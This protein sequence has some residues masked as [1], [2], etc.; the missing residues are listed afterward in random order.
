MLDM[1]QIENL[2][3]EGG[4]IKCYAY[5]P[6]LKNLL[7]YFPKFLKQIK[8]YAGTSAGSIIATF[9]CLDTDLDE[10]TEIIK[11]F[12]KVEIISNSYFKFFWNIYYL[13]YRFGMN[14]N[15]VLEELL[16]KAIRDRWCEITSIKDYDP[17]F[18][19]I[20]DLLNKDLIITSS[21]IN[22]QGLVYFSSISTP[23]VPIYKAILSSCC[24]PG[25]FNPV[26]YDFNPDKSCK[27]YLVDGGL[28]LNYPIFVFDSLD[29][30]HSFK[31]ES[32][33]KKTLGFAIITNSDML[34]ERKIENFTNFS[35]NI[36]SILST[37][38]A[39]IYMKENDWDRTI[40]IFT[41]HYEISDL[42]LDNKRKDLDRNGMES[43]NYFIKNN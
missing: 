15:Q 32:V 21:N 43:I 17:T 7:Q 25:I 8:G 35:L 37:Q 6:A 20:K 9:L 42:N 1:Y 14:S 19:D 5:I 10:I 23:K 22:T 12:S 11:N 26:K 36:I 30:Y 18:Y 3:F 33:N 40:K 38:I 31:T 2:V 27:H 29:P 13:F 34:N 28:I 4:G 39:K 24:I 16:K 41:K